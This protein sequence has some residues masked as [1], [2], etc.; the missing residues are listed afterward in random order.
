M[1]IKKEKYPTIYLIG[2]FGNGWRDEVIDS[3][4]DF[5]FNDPRN[6]Q[7]SSIT[8]LDYSDMKAAMESDI[9]L[10]TIP[11]G[12][13]AGTMSYCELGGARAKGKCIIAIDENENKD[14]LLKKIASHHYSTREGVLELLRE[15]E[16]KPKYPK[17]KT[18][19]K[20]K[21]RDEYQNILFAGDLQTIEPLIKEMEKTKKVLRGRNPKNL[22]NFSEE[23]DLIV[24]NFDNGKPHEKHGLFYMGVGYATKVPIL[25]LEGNSV[26]YP[27]L[28][29]LARRVLVGRDRFK[30]A[31]EYLTNLKSQHIDD[32]ALVY[33]NLMKKFNN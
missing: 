21:I 2:S 8:R 18:K 11:N 19:D 28:L 33:Y 5:D 3:L 16:Y 6:H 17:I 9:A 32:E 31:K 23:T 29:G 24:V 14:S 12:K 13:R 27:P 15:N 7:Q 25:E 20:T 22:E 26:P 1:N 4:A 10:T 30:Q